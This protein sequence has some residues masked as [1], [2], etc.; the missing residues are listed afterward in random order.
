MA[1]II[2]DTGCANLASV[3]FACERLGVQ[4]LVTQNPQLVESAEHVILPGVGA[5]P[6]A[7]QALAERGLIAVLQNLSQPLLGIC[8]GMQ[9]L[10]EGS[11]E[12]NAK[13][14]GRIK[15]KASHLQAAGLPLPHMGWNTLQICRDD[16]L[17]HGIKS[18]EYAYFVHSYAVPVTANTLASTQY[19]EP[20]SAIVRHGNVYGCQFHPERSGKLG[21]RILRNFLETSA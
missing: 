17:L 4:P 11:E 20:F 6:F 8:L 18:G 10:F 16:P 21:A 15:G 1:V 19:G 9:I 12:G 3:A 2:V 7:M 5:M 14:L 13:G